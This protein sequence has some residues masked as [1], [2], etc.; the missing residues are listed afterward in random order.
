MLI[1]FEAYLRA[2]SGL[3]RARLFNKTDNAVVPGSEVSTTSGLR[4]RVRSGALTLVDGK[5]YVTQIGAETGVDATEI[6]SSRWI[7]A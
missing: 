1:F 3:A 7:A 6:F 2:V 4:T 5:E